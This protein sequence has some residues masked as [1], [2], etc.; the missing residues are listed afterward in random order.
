MPG[1]FG[2]ICK[3][4]GDR[5]ANEVLIR[6]MGELQAHTR[7]YETQTYA[8]SWC[9]LGLIGLPVPGEERFAVD[10]NRGLAAAFG[11]FIYGFQKLS[12]DLMQPTT[13]KATR[14]LDIYANDAVSMPEKLNGSYNAVVIDLRNRR[15]TIANDRLGHWQLYFF[16]DNDRLLFAGEVKA[17]LAYE[18]F[19]RELDPEG[20]YAYLNYQVHLGD[21]TFFKGVK[22]LPWAHQIVV[23]NG[24]VRIN[25]WWEWRFE[26]ET[27]QTIPE[28]VEEG[29]KLYQEN[30]RLQ[31]HGAKHVAIPLSGGLD[32]RMVLAHATA[33]GLEPETFSHGPKRS[34]EMRFA[35]RVAKAA[36]IKHH[37][38]IEI[39][40]AWSYE[41]AER[42][43]WLTDGLVN[44]NPCVLLGVT[45][46]YGLPPA[47]TAFL[48]GLA[49][50][51][52]FGYGYF[53]ASD[54][55]R[56]LTREQKLDRLRRSLVGQYVDDNY[57]RMF[58][59]DIRPKLKER[60]DAAIEA[61][62][63]Q[64]EKV[65]DLFCHQRDLFTL[66]NRLK[67]R[68][69]Q[70]DVNRFI[71]HDHF[72]LEDDRTLD[73]YIKLPPALKA[74]PIR[75]LLI[76]GLKQKFPHLAAVPQQ[77]SGVDLYSQPS[78]WRTMLKGY[79]RRVAYYT[80]RLSF[81]LVNIRDMD[82]YVHYNQWY[83][84]NRKLREFIDGILLDPR[85]LNRGYFDPAGVR[86]MLAYQK[87]GG[88]TFDELAMLVSF[89]LFHRQF[90]D[91][92]S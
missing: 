1:I 45:E 27:S 9:G 39:D 66:Q 90:I 16:E 60:Y 69:D 62:F 4:G 37:R 75:T 10:Q 33:A 34:L 35:T 77:H 73:F 36:G 5:G 87:R 17:L 41:Y 80:E 44:I 40:P 26:T 24:Q 71:L 76:E 31:T 53:N 57:Y 59:P 68:F 89:E 50:R 88:N 23:D 65:S 29:H 12:D 43:T 49:G 32:S 61:D 8:E 67:R 48:N 70:I 91:R 21:T 19:S 54:I 51:T 38:I 52:A 82:T 28:L 20:V 42:F 74:Y 3:Q 58:H 30:I 13:R 92:W 55:S 15:M 56:T 2:F 25:P 84:T 63:A 85:T 14:I 6:K 7:G 47:D 78:K 46:R 83:R 72:A 11:G 86:S 81:G 64:Y 18:R 22:R 79:G